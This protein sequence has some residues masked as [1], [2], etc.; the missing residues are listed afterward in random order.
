MEVHHALMLLMETETHLSS[1]VGVCL[2]LLQ[3]HP[4]YGRIM[5][6]MSPQHHKTILNLLGESQPQNSRLLDDYSLKI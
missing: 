4:E 1:S 2:A 6:D 3:L 5:K